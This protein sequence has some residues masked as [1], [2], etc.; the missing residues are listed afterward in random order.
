MAPSNRTDRSKRIDRVADEMGEAPH[1]TPKI[2]GKKRKKEETGMYVELRK[3]KE[4]REEAAELKRIKD[5]VKEQEKF[6]KAQ[7]KVEKEHEKVRRA[8]EKAEHEQERLKKAREKAEKDE[9]KEQ[10]RA[11][12]KES[13]DAEKETKRLKALAEKEE[14]DKKAKEKDAKEAEKETKKK[15]QQ[16]ALKKQASFMGKF[17]AKAASPGKSHGQDGD[18]GQGVEGEGEAA[19]HLEERIQAVVVKM[20][21]GLVD[22][23]EATTSQLLEYVTT[24]SFCKPSMTQATITS[25]SL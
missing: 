1:S 14:K 12:E 22:C 6:K 17:L 24:N 10:E 23:G 18:R 9:E 16:D 3:K 11:K 25:S 2:E 8:E 19:R 21:A 13:K 5:D 4:K 15:K 7:E 20:D